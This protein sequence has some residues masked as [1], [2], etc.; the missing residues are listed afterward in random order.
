VNKTSYKPLALSWTIVGVM[1]ALAFCRQAAPAKQSQEQTPPAAAP[2]A[3]PEQTP[4]VPP[5]AARAQKPQASI[6]KAWEILKE[7]IGETK[8]DKRAKAV[9]SLGL[10]PAN[11]TAEKFAMAA[12]KDDK[13][14]VRSAAATALGS[15]HATRARAALEKALDDAEPSVVLAAAN[16]LLL[17][18]DKLGYDVYY[19]VL[20][21][22]M[23]TN[24][25]LIKEQMKILRDPKRMTEMGIEEGIGFIPFAGIGYTVVRTVTK[26]DSSLVRAAAAKK[27]AH[28]PDRLSADALVMATSDKNWIVRAA[29]LEALAQRGDRSVLPKITGTMDDAKDDVRYT[30]AACVV[31]LSQLGQRR[32]SSSGLPATTKKSEDPVQ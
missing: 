29:A 7:G 5:A 16:S 26:D 15:M 27:L 32:H 23:R 3:K 22:N 9:N 14:N 6:D 8:A 21:G 19:G 31:H 25:G 30:A 4:S 11:S 10:V 20:T 18:N 13:D 1:S 28:D 17:L 12:L 24:K 2:E